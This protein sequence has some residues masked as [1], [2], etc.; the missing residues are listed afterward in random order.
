MTKTFTAMSVQRWTDEH[1]QRLF[2]W[3]HEH[4]LNENQTWKLTVNDCNFEAIIYRLNHEGKRYMDPETQDVAKTSVK[5]KV[6]RP[7]PA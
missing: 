6:K 5:G 3:M 7:C 4:G 1:K 2:V